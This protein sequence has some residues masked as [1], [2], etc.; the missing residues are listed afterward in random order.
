MAK[1]RQERLALEERERQARQE[2]IVELGEVVL[3]AGAE[4]VS[5]GELK[6]LLVAAMALGPAKA[7]ELLRGASGLKTGGR[8]ANGAAESPGF[9][10]AES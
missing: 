5:P 7:I 10:H 1:V 8:R 9:S 4:D 3:D 6:Q 2:A